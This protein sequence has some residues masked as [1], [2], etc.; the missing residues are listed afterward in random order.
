MIAGLTGP[1]IRHA[2]LRSCLEELPADYAVEHGA[3]GVWAVQRDFR[4][5]LVAA[6]LGPDDRGHASP[7]DL[8]GRRTL[9]EVSVGAQRL[10]VRDFGH[11]GLLRWLSGT[12][13]LDP[14]RPFRELI[15]AR[16]LAR[17]DVHT[18]QAIAACARRAPGFGWHLSLVTRRVEGAT[19]LKTVLERLAVS[20][21]PPRGASLGE[22]DRRLSAARLFERAGAFVGHVHRVGFLHTDL[23]PRNMLV[24]DALLAGGGGHLWLLD[25]DR[26]ELRAE[27]TRAERLDGLRR[28]WRYILRREAGLGRALTRARAG[29]FLRAY[30]AS[31]GAGAADW[32][33]DWRDIVRG[34]RR[35]SALHRAGWWAEDLFRGGP[36]W[37]EPS[38]R[39]PPSDDFGSA[40]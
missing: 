3:R 28:L 25:L 7:S 22:P 15:L 12:R 1:S 36:A 14:T 9:G 20:P 6:G 11:G 16:R 2:N 40:S 23:T 5:G 10:V 30:G 18:P 34:T 21:Y 17:L 29:R 24:D 31:L 19:E 8:G 26:C 4:D 33:A 39:A 32:R 37:R 13:F 38:R 35:A 27:L